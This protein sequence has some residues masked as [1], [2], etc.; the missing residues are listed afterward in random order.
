MVGD[1]PF[2]R[3]DGDSEGSGAADPAVRRITEGR[4]WW[5]VL[6]FGVPLVV[7][8]AL[9]TT[10]NLIDMF[11]IS[12]LENAKEALGALGICDMVAALPKEQRL[13]V[14]QRAVR[15]GVEED[16]VKG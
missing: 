9:Y 2:G 13:R 4:L 5:G 6:R 14:R 8:M 3:D 15:P 7:G 11:M 16:F 12:R 1:R 10:F